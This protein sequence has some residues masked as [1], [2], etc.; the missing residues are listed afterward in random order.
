MRRPL[1][2]AQQLFALQLAVVVLLIAGAGVLA[3]FDAR[4]ISEAAA[5]RRVLTLA[6]ALAE[7][8]D[9]HNAL[10]AADPA[11][12]LQPLAQSVA[13]ATASDFIVFMATD[14]TRYSH[15]NASLIG[16]PYIGTIDG[17]L[18]GGVVTETY[19]GTLGPSV[20][21]VVPIRDADDN[22]TA[23][24]SIGVLQYHVGREVRER[25]TLLAVAAAGA[26]LISAGGTLLISRR[27]SR[28]TL[29]LG[30]AE[31]TRMYEQHD[32]VLRAVREG[33]LIVDTQG[34][35]V[36]ANDEARRLLELPAAA[37]DQ[38][39]RGLNVEEPLRSWLATG[40]T[41]VDRLVVYRD[42]VLVVNSEPAVKDARV[43][44]TVT[45]LRDHTEL[46]TLTG[47]LDSARG[48]AE[49]LRAQAHEAANRL[50][51][52]VTM[53]EL[54]QPDKAVE[55][56]TVELQAAQQLTD[57]VVGAVEEPALAALLLSKAAQAHEKGVELVITEETEVTALSDIGTGMSPRE[58]VTVVGNLVDNA[59][60]AAVA[61]PPPRQ[62][63]LA[64]YTDHTGFWLSVT[65]TGSGLPPG[66]SEN[67]F[68]RGWSTKTTDAPH[69]RGLGLA[70]V[71]QIVTRHHG[72]IDAYPGDSAV[73]SDGPSPGAT[74]QIHI[75]LRSEA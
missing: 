23:L 26:L 32:A 50:H 53:I 54:G 66:D 59:I 30:P 34:C 45:T 48:F 6:S 64:A 10:Q 52:V 47:E 41:L 11:A 60:D 75:P 70:L 73:S 2:L 13:N 72:T 62:V 29:G 16:Q 18:E 49:A 12:E 39:V 21:A 37:V 28:Q 15:P 68:V 65:D 1:S 25:L 27:L 74:F 40:E 63:V 14:R 31:I 24:V 35:L 4:R 7:L 55:F 69:G 3:Y 71:K 8:P 56:A 22:V 43:L 9:V 58:I 36:L 5:E 19:E 57:R 17:A 51:T 67:I 38:N 42:R 44:G 46:E 61:A 20:R 33:L